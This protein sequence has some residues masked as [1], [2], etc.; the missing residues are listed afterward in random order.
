MGKFKIQRP[1]LYLSNYLCCWKMSSSYCHRRPVFNTIS[2]DK[3]L[4]MT[5]R[6]FTYNP[7]LQEQWRRGNIISKRA[8][9]Q[10]E[11]T[12]T[13]TSAHPAIKFLASWESATEN[14][15]MI[16]GFCGVPPDFIHHMKGHTSLSLSL[17]ADRFHQRP[18]RDWITFEDSPLALKGNHWQ[19]KNKSRKPASLHNGSSVVKR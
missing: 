19:A 3:L 11:E 18:F 15:T 8:K 13:R 16:I 5:K 4:E 6:D 7:L 17:R 10:Y 14:D 9:R 12:S 2:K 1:H